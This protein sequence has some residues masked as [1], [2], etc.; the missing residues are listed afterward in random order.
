LE[1]Q[2]MVARIRIRSLAIITLQTAER[3]INAVIEVFRVAA[4]KALGWDIF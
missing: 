1:D 2:K 4:N 3:L